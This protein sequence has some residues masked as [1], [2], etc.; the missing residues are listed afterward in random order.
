[1][2]ANAPGQK[3]ESAADLIELLEVR[4]AP[5]PDGDTGEG[6]RFR[7]N[8]GEFN[9][10]V[11]RAPDSDRA[12]IW[13][14]GARGGFGGPGPGIYAKLAEELTGKGITSVRL[15]YRIPSDLLECVLDL[16][17]GVT[18]CKSEGCDS[19]VVVGHSFGGAVVIAGG[20]SSPD[21]K[22]VVSL[23]PQ[24]HGAGMAGMPGPS[25]ALGGPRQGRH[26]PPLL[27][28]PTDIRLG[29]RAQGTRALRRGG[30]PAGRM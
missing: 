10:I 2:T 30:T 16:L 11:H 18:Y 7:T 19:I 29:E 20:A 21:V 9:G 3:P 27:L 25:P 23:S 5:L 1:M 28:R 13:V 24:T 12:V 6:L 8:R 17:A 22:G 26:P 15:D 4:E 14:C